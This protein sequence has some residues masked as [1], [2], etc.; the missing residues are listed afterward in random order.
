[1][2][3][4]EKN[5]RLFKTVKEKALDRYCQNVLDETT[6]LCTEDGKTAHERYLAVWVHIQESNKAMVQP[7]DAHSRSRA[8]L[9]L[10]IMRDMGLVDEED[11]QQFDADLLR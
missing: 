11:I 5:W 9:Q 1:M 3:I 10:E 4:P 8:M 2:T 6:R 7:F